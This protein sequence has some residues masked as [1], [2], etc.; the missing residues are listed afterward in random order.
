[1][2][3]KDFKI[4][5]VFG[6]ICLLGLLAWLATRQS[7]STDA[8]LA[9]SFGQSQTQSPAAPPVNTVPSTLEQTTVNASPARE[10]IEQPVVVQE[11]TPEI[12]PEAPVFVGI[13]P[14]MNAPEDPATD[15]SGPKITTNRFHIAQR[16]ETLS[17]ISQKLYGT[18]K[19]WPKILQANSERLSSPEKLQPGMYLV[20]PD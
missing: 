3:Q 16:G 6:A 7:L 17:G 13:E 2:M 18:S 8:R 1:M 15:P 9:R 14:D 19:L 20:I 5:L 11:T 10:T 4:G 12:T